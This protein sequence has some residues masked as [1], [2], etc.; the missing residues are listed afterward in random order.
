VTVLRTGRSS[1]EGCI[2]SSRSSSPSGMQKSQRSAGELMYL[3]V[4]MSRVQGNRILQ[5]ARMK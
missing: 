1:F 5:T 2:Y 3:G 4:F